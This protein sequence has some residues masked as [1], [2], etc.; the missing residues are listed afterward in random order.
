MPSLFRGCATVCGSSIFLLSLS[1][2]LIARGWGFSF[3]V[4]SI[5]RNARRDEERLN[6]LFHC[7][8]IGFH[9]GNGGE[10]VRHSKGKGK[11]LKLDRH[12]L[13]VFIVFGSLLVFGALW[14]RKGKRGIFLYMTVYFFSLHSFAN[15]FFIYIVFVFTSEFVL[16]FLLVFFTL[17]KAPD[18]SRFEILVMLY[19][20]TFPFSYCNIL[21]V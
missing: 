20:K 10:A 6:D 1:Y 8:S 3:G 13:V 4:Y 18:I 14:M 16:L 17:A 21:C 19:P 15:H 12:S 9:T 5:D 2:H 11:E 7:K